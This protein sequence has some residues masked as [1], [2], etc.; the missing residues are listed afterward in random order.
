[1]AK[2]PLELELL[3]VV[4]QHRDAGNQTYVLWAQFVK[5]LCGGLNENAP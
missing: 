4:N 5:P 3:T 2:V 1:M